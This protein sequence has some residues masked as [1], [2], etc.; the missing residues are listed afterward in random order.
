M[1]K[2]QVIE[3]AQAASYRLGHKGGHTVGEGPDQSL[4]QGPGHEEDLP[5]LGPLCGGG[6]GLLTSA[7]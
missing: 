2:P 1:P 7:G 4:V 6:G 5:S 3:P